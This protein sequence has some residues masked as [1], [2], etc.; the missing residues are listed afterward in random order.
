MKRRTCES[1]EGSH[2]ARVLLA[3]WRTCFVSELATLQTCL[4]PEI[5]GFSTVLLDIALNL[6]HKGHIFF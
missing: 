2:C 1:V 4:L 3:A 6:S 5:L